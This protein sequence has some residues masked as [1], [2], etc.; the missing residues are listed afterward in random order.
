MPET[1]V[2]DA[3]EQKADAKSSDVKDN[4]P[5]IYSEEV[6]KEVVKQR[7]EIKDRLRS[8]E[9]ANEENTRKYQEEQLKSKG[10][11]ET[12]AKIKTEQSQIAVEAAHEYITDAYLSRLGSK[13]GIIDE[14]AISMF[15]VEFEFSDDFKIM[16][17]DEVEKKFQEWVKA[18]PYLFKPIDKKPV[19]KTDTQIPQTKLDVSPGKISIVEILQERALKR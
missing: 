15:A 19:P 2:V 12:L 3:T 7:D 18:K 16:N 9:L 10:D 11:Y 1:K 4:Q 14:E 13:Y 6:F 17:S 5:K 8:I